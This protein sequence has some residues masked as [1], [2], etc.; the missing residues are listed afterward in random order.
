MQNVLEN[1]IDIIVN[2]LNNAATEIK[3][4]NN[5]SGLSYFFDP[6]NDLQGY[7]SLRILT[8]S[9]Y[10][11]ILDNL[12]ENT[13][14]I[15]NLLNR[16]LVKEQEDKLI[17]NISLTGFYRNRLEKIIHLNGVK[18][19]TTFD[20]FII[21][22]KEKTNF[23]VYKAQE[24]CVK[25]I[26]ETFHPDLMFRIFETLNSKISQHKDLEKLLIERD[27]LFEISNNIDKHFTDK[28]HKEIQE[29]RKQID[30]TK[31]NAEE[32]INK[33]VNKIEKELETATEGLDN[34]IN[35]ISEKIEQIQERI[36]DTPQNIKLYNADYKKK[37]NEYLNSYADL[38]NFISIN[39]QTLAMP[40]TSENLKTKINLQNILTGEELNAI[41]A[42]K[43][44]GTQEKAASKLNKTKATIIKQLES[45]RNK[46]KE[47]HNLQGQLTTN[48][49]IKML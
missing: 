47:A 23:F 38:I 9:E 2:R 34:K 29:A 25:N 15:Y 7:K 19:N 20:D 27:N 12:I 45:A 22:I 46:V 17:G 18:Y 26:I 30:E 13:Y 14:H 39:L 21:Y 42:V 48:E 31:E 37:F 4:S 40:D 41:R 28:R 1:N 11:R 33:I 43:E 6:E 36:Y 32:I 44:N 10:L 3:K 5:Y 35:N 8:N 16:E 24:I 49:L